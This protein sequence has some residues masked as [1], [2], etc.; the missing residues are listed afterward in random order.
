[1]NYD[2]IQLKVNEAIHHLELEIEGHTAFIDYKL[3]KE[4]LFLIHTEVPRELEGK[5]VGTAI[6]S[7]ALQYAKDNGYTI[8][9]ICPFVQAYLKKHP[10]WKEIVSPDADRFIHAPGN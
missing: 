3:L 8:V 1:M 10:E 7:K 6:I 5:G 4:K 2:G 9:P